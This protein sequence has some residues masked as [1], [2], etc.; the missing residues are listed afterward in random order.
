MA[1]VVHA[2]LKELGINPQS[3]VQPSPDVY[4][5][6][7]YGFMPI[8]KYTGSPSVSVPLYSIKFEELNIPLTLSYSQNGLKVNEEASWVGLGW[9]LSSNA[10]ITRSLKDGDDLNEYNSQVAGSKCGWIYMPIYQPWGNDP[11]QFL[12]PDDIVG[13]IADK[14]ADTGGNSKYRPD[15]EQDVF[16]VS[17]F[18]TSIRFVLN[19]KGSGNIIQGT[20]LNDRLHIITLDLTTKSF[21]IVDGKGYQYI[22]G[23][24]ENSTTYGTYAAGFDIITS[25]FVDKIIAPS[26]KELLFSYDTSAGQ[27]LRSPD[28]VSQSGSFRYCIEGQGNTTLGTGGSSSTTYTVNSYIRLLNI[29]NG[30]EK[31]VFVANDRLDIRTTGS[32]K[33]KKLDK[34]QLLFNDVLKKEIILHTSYFD[35]PQAADAENYLYLRL[36]LDAI[37]VNDQ[38]HHFYYLQENNLPSKHSKAVDLWGYYNGKNNSS[39][40][41][42]F[43]GVS[44]EYCD[45]EEV[46]AS[47]GSADRD[48]DHTF[49]KIGQLVKVQYPTGGA[50][51]LTYENNSV[52]RNYNDHYLWERAEPLSPTQYINYS[53]TASATHSFTLPLTTS[54]SETSEQGRIEFNL[55]KYGAPINIYG[56]LQAHMNE[57]A[58]TLTSST[59]TL[60][61]VTF[62]EFR[63][64]CEPKDLQTNC[65][66]STP[67][68][69]SCYCDRSVSFFTGTLPPGTYTITLSAKVAGLSPSVKISYPTDQYRNKEVGGLRIQYLVD[70]EA[71][72]TIVSKRKFEYTDASGY[73]SG[74]LMAAPLFVQW[75]RGYEEE[76]TDPDLCHVAIRNVKWITL[77][78]APS[79]AIFNSTQGTHIGYGT[80][81]EIFMS[82]ANPSEN[83]RQESTFVNEPNGTLQSVDVG[84]TQ[85]NVATFCTLNILDY[86]FHTES[87]I[88]GSGLEE[89]VADEQNGL[90]LSEKYYTSSGVL[91]KSIV[92]TYSGISYTGS[93]NSTLYI[94]TKLFIR[95]TNYAPYNTNL[96]DGYQN[97]YRPITRFALTS[98]V[99]TTFSDGSEHSVARHIS[100]TNRWLEQETETYEST[101]FPVKVKTYYPQDYS[102]LTSLTNQ[103]ILEKPVKVEQIQNGNLLDAKVLEYS[104]IGQPVREHRYES[105]GISA[106]PVHDA[107]VMVPSGYSLKTEM[108]YYTTAHKPKESIGPDGVPIVYYWGYDNR[109]LVAMIKG[110]KYADIT[111]TL[112]DA[113]LQAPASDAALRT[114]LNKLRAIPGAMVTT[115]TV[116]P[117][118]GMTSVTDLN[119]VTTYF[120]YDS[121]DRLKLI[122]NNGSEILKRFTYH[123][124]Q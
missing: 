64:Y 53:T 3:L 102:I 71:N 111:V 109:Y 52:R 95:S 108:S 84:A 31:L 1:S 24:K 68:S 23:T 86:Y 76:I 20:A 13:D 21:T 67:A 38:W 74:N 55:I 83:Y 91:V 49:S 8:G 11:L 89:R 107:A 97:Y 5:L 69:Y 73:S 28:N 75:N 90:L 9:S 116:N 37:S 115:Y 26:G 51:E 92:N 119:N 99:E 118:V 98:S 12:I 94:N 112:N 80:V 66:I 50:T 62:G 47:G 61:T 18:G 70:K 22:F 36:K 27:I 81:S 56:E 124:K 25:W 16:V 85:V 104:S 10:V 93:P 100:Y 65:T 82:D 110:V 57:T 117:T 44:P 6:G 30:S 17:L 7:K 32:T 4:S 106:A 2:Q 120:N 29:I 46:S 42:K 41:P 60:H 101:G 19:K 114:E 122:Q 121:A 105:P 35:Q 34:I 58:I 39:L 78:S 103:N 43:W 123:Y 59:G 77:S 45:F 96:V 79:N 15:L 72:G 14:N 88:A 63:T 40:I 87:G 113:I 33:T 54:F 48:A